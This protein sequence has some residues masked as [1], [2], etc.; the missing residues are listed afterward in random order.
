MTIN[1]YLKEIETQSKKP[2]NV[3]LNDLKISAAKFLST[4]DNL[5]ETLSSE[6]TKS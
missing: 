2:I 6:E 5:I 3:Q 1:Q 4:L